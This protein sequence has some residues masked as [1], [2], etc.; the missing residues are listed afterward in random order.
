[1]EK[2]IKYACGVDISLK[3]FDVCFISLDI[4]MGDKVKGTKKFDNN[5]SGIKSFCD[6]LHLKSKEVDVPLSILIEATGVYHEELAYA[7]S[8]NGFRISVILPNKSQKYLQSLG[9]K[10]K[11]D[12]IDAYGL[13]LMCAQQKL[14]EFKPLDPFYYELRALTRFY[15]N[16]QESI[17]ALGN[18]LHATEHGY[19]TSSEITSEM[20]SLLKTKKDLLKRIVKQMHALVKSREDIREKIERILKVKGIGFLTIVTVI[21]ETGGFENFDNIPGLV[22]YA[23]FDVIEN[24]SG[25]HVGKTKISKKGNSRIRRVL[26]LPSLVVVKYEPSFNI[27]YNRIFEKSYIPMKG[28][29]AVQKKMLVLIYSMWKNDTEFNPDLYVQKLENRSSTDKSVLHKVEH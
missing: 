10:S 19:Y 8:S 18:Q 22:S 9:L 15:Q 28:Y 23:G 11:N 3:K 5:A 20:K 14:E 7:L 29:V 26:H 17:T 27:F 2:I 4:S 13:S 21:A 16:V 6:W 25:M 24:Q 12:K 1:M